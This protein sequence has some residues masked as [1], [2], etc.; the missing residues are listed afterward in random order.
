MGL[1]SL[2][3]KYFGYGHFKL[4]EFAKSITYYQK[5]KPADMDESSTYNRLLAEG[6]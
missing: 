1:A 4:S 3:N 6:I 2:I 5:I